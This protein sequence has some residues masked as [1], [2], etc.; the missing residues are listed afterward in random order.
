MKLSPARMAKV[1]WTF[2]FWAIGVPLQLVLLVAVFCGC[3]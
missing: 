1:D 3:G 2:L